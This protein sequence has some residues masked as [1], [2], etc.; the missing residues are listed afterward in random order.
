ML[1]LLQKDAKQMLSPMLSIKTIELLHSGK[2]LIR[3]T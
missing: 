2:L 3:N 1:Q